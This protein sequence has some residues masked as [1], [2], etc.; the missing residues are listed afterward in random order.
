M[1]NKKLPHPLR[2]LCVCTGTAPSCCVTTSGG[3]NNRT[4]F[5]ADDTHGKCHSKWKV[6]K[7]LQKVA[8]M[9]HTGNV[10]LP[11]KI[12]LVSGETLHAYLPHLH[13]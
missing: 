9:L 4:E 8:Q 12:L 7:T 2:R 5:A 3:E 13:R 10:N 1:P 6:D 11:G